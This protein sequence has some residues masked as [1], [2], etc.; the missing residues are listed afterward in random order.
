VSRPRYL[1]DND[2]REQIII[3]VLRRAP[4]VE[5]LRARDLGL[6][7][8]PDAVVLAYAARQ[9][10]V[11]VSH[12]VNTMSATAYERLA[13]GQEIHGLLIARQTGNL[14]A[15]VDSLVLIATSSESEEWRGRVV[16]L[17]L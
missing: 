2:L 6:A 5:F 13:A 3:G 15:V 4:D 10:L 12:D 8:L 17:P 7:N 11:V 16:F 9:G 1:A 14:G